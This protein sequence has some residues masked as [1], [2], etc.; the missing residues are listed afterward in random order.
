MGRV[1]QLAVVQDRHVLVR[2]FEMLDIVWD[3]WADHVVGYHNSPLRDQPILLQEL[4][5]F[6][7]H[8]LPVV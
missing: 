3:P 5:V 7:V 1:L 6:E 8:I 4:E 2:G